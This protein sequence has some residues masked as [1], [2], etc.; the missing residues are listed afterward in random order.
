MYVYVRASAGFFEEGPGGHYGGVS[1]RHCIIKCNADAFRSLHMYGVIYVHGA[2][3][4]P[5]LMV[6]VRPPV[7]H[8]QGK[9]DFSVS[10]YIHIRIIPSDR[11][12]VYFNGGAAIIF[13]M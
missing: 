1:G 9:V 6:T 8:V 3:Y 12:N 10:L 5:E 11:A 2:H 13:H 4:A 7:Q